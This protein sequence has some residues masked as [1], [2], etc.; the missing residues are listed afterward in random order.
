MTLSQL[1]NRHGLPVYKRS[2]CCCLLKAWERNTFFSA[3]FR[4]LLEGA[5]QHDQDAIAE[6]L[7]SQWIPTQ[8]YHQE[9]VIGFRGFFLS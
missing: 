2:C 5:V 3:C 8:I 4:T 1:P 9:K 6:E 7:L